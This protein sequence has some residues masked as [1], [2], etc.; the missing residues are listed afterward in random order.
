MQ[1]RAEQVES[2]P[3]AAGNAAVAGPPAPNAG[4]VG[5]VA[6]IAQDCGACAIFAYVDAAAEPGLDLSEGHGASVYYVT[7]D[8][9]EENTRVARGQRVIRVP[10]VALTRFGQVRIALLIARSRGLLRPGDTIVC[11]TGLAESGALDTIVVMQVGRQFD[12]FLAP[13]GEHEIAPHVLPEVLERVI[14]VAAELGS[15]GREGKA[16]GALFVVGDSERVRPLTRQL[17][18]NPFQ[19]YPEEQRNILD[20]SLEE[21]VKELTT[22][23]GA[24][25]V[26]SDGVLEAAGAYLRAPADENALLPQGLGSRHCAAA[27]ITAVTDAVAVTVSQSTGTVTIFQGG[28]IVTEIEKPRGAGRGWRF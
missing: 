7:K 15:E 28:R 12:M 27:G 8:V 9:M 5:Y 2:E 6:R 19:G 26:R 22:I 17:I 21:T 16:V 10:N 1:N 24:F 20:P 4:L 13:D 23:D 11:L 14:G 3:A 18:L 25:L